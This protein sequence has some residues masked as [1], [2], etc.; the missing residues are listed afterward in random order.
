MLYVTGVI[1]TM[2]DAIII[3]SNNSYVNNFASNPCHEKIAD[4]QAEGAHRTNGQANLYEPATT[5]SACQKAGRS[6]ASHLMLQ[7]AFKL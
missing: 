3:K 7:D 2:Y 5:R 6:P 4:R 1:H